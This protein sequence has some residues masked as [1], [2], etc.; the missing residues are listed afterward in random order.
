MF[1]TAIFI[2]PANKGTLDEKRMQEIFRK[3]IAGTSDLFAEIHKTKE[4]GVSLVSCAIL[5]TFE[6][7]L[8][9]EFCE[10]LKNGLMAKKCG[11]YGRYFVSK[12]NRNR[13]YCNRIYS[14]NRTCK[15]LG[16]KVLYK[17]NTEDDPYLARYED[18]RQT[19]YSRKYRADGKQ[20]DE[21]FGK[22]MTDE[23]YVTWSEMATWERLQYLAGE[24]TGDELISSITTD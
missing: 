21:L 4:K 2:I 15:D 11:L 1:K 16:A 24:I 6:E 8:Y 12:D 13:K 18:I 3:Q 7:F 19:Y 14:G 17:E 9:F 23:E 20:P 5:E 22:D 10:M